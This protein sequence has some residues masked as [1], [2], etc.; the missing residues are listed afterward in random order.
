M[1]NFGESERDG[2]LDQKIARAQKNSPTCVVPWL[3]GQARSVSMPLQK[4]GGLL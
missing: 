2:K 1:K 4:T 3:F